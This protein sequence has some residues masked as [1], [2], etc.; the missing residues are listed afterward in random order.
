M[1]GPLRCYAGVPDE[2]QPQ[3]VK[4]R[5]AMANGQPDRG[6]TEKMA[7]GLAAPA[8]GVIPKRQGA[9]H[10]A[11]GKNRSSHHL[12]PAE[13]ERD[14]RW[15]PVNNCTQPTSRRS[16]HCVS[17]PPVPQ[18]RTWQPLP[19]A[20]SADKPE[21][22]HAGQLFGTADQRSNPAHW[23]A[24]STAHNQPDS[25]QAPRPVDI[26]QHR[27]GLH[28]LAGADSCSVLYFPLPGCLA[29]VMR[30]TQVRGND[31]HHNHFNPRFWRDHPRLMN[32]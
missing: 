3:P 30:Y 17:R 18:D 25:T 15:Q 8:E 6:R 14:G 23:H 16:S 10:N 5:G 24:W 11:G 1:I 21:T 2:D 20:G 9:R 32:L 22:R 19:T 27:P 28:A 4:T 31:S 26:G 13:K 12:L 29:L 7:A